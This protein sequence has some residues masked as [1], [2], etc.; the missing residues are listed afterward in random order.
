MD[1]TTY[2]KYLLKQGSTV[3][4]AL[5]QLN[6]LAKD[7]I[8]FIV[9]EDFKLVGS[10]TDGD[11]RRGLLKGVGIENLVDDI[12]EPNPRFLR[13]GDRDITKVIEYR[14]NNFRIIPILDKDGTVVNVINFQELKSYLPIDVVI[15]AGGRGERLRPLTDKV[16]KPLLKVGAKPILEHN[17]DRLALFG[18]DDFWISVKYLG[19][20]ISAYF[21]DGSERN[22][23]IQY[24]WEEFP[25]GTIG[26][27]SKIDNFQHEY[28]LVTNSDLLTN[29]DFEHFFLDFLSQ[30]ADLS[31]VTIPYQVSIPYAVLETENN[32][33]TSLKEKPSY[34]YYSN[35]GIYLMKRGVLSEIPKGEYFDATNLMEALIK[36]DYKVLSYPLS[37]YW[38]DVGSLQDFEKAQKDIQ[39][40]KF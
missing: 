4:E 1:L 31:V 18:I 13:K 36:N 32:L 12:I 38:L 35:G 39:Q 23:Q 16:P 2:K 30:G 15:M 19:D 25:L 21:G 22:V 9:T 6:I 29:L 7:A 14:D 3:K 34:T 20:Q 5:A 24:V 10:L 11:V 27:V 28:V 33:V 37:G 40:I 8:V 26:A 17:L